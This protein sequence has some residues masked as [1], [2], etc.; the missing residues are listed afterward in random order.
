MVG[1]RY[2]SSV[3][4]KALDDIFLLQRKLWHNTLLSIHSAP[5]PCRSCG[6]KGPDR[7]DRRYNWG[8]YWANRG[9]CEAF[10]SMLFKIMIRMC[11]PLVPF[12]I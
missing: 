11:S 12:E 2:E 9:I 8:K 10:C 4:I 6:E 7:K 1:L 3:S 5:N